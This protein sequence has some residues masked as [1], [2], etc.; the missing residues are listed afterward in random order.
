MFTVTVYTLQRIWAANLK[1][2]GPPL[3]LAYRPDKVYWSD[4]KHF[5]PLGPSDRHYNVSFDLLCKQK[6]S[7]KPQMSGSTPQ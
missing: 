3:E 4:N 2:S 1:L 6:V 5:R 7:G